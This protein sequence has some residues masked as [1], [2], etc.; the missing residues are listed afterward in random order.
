MATKT[1]KWLIMQ[2]V[3]W[4]MDNGCFRNEDNE[5]ENYFT[6]Q[7]GKKGKPCF[8]KSFPSYKANWPQVRQAAY[9]D[10]VILGYKTRFGWFLGNE[11]DLGNYMAQLHKGNETR[12]A[13]LDKEIHYLMLMGDET[14]MGLVLEAYNSKR[15]QNKELTFPMVSQA[16]KE[17]YL[18]MGIP[19]Q[20]HFLP[21][22][23]ASLEDV[24][25]TE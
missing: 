2:V 15:E 4:A 11:T 17:F 24:D 5:I 8:T 9:E 22:L 13:S 16:I 14:N 6:I 12:I 20:E 23:D 18:A 21:L 7:P 10:G 19:Y 25:E 3:G 1:Y